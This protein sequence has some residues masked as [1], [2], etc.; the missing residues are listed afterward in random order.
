MGTVSILQVGKSYG[1]FYGYT[2]SGVFQ[3]Q[4]QVNSYVN[5]NGD[6]I[7]PMQNLEILFGKTIMAME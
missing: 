1:T 7:L 4:A 6:K 5:A 3:N 2:Y